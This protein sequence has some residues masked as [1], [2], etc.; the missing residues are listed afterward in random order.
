M[1][2]NH[3]LTRIDPNEREDRADYPSGVGRD[4][5]LHASAASEAV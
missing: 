2:T 5:A 1:K 3:E 4:R